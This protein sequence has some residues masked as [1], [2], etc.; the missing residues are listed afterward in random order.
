MSSGSLKMICHG[1]YC[2]GIRTIYGFGS[3]LDAPQIGLTNG[4]PTR[5][6]A[7]AAGYMSPDSPPNVWQPGSWLSGRSNG[8]GDT[9]PPETAEERFTRYIEYGRRI[10]PQGLTEVVIITSSWSHV[11]QAV[12]I[13]VLEKL[14]LTKVTECHNSNSG[15][16]LHVYYDIRDL[17][18]PPPAKKPPTVDEFLSL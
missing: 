5:E 6:D 18:Q 1:G 7:I 14:G 10:R 3:R 17:P 16:R 12:W 13:P 9:A 15:N 4:L 2:C 8:F 11:T